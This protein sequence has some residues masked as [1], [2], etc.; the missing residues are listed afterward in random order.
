M[1]KRELKLNFKSFLIWTLILLGMFLAVF[2]VYPY[3]MTSENVDMLN[4][5]MK[6]FPPEVLKAF[7]MDISEIDTAFGWL[8]TEGFIFVLLISGIFS[9]ILGSNIVLKEESDKTIEYLHNL[10]I[11][12]TKIVT[13]KVLCALTYI[14]SMILVLGIFNYIGLSLSGDFNQ[15][16]YIL[17][18]ISP[19]FSALVTFSLCLFISTFTH[20]TK[21]TMG[22]SLGIVF[23]SYFLQILSELSDKVEFLKYISTFTL[24]DTRNIIS[25]NT[26]NPLCIIISILLTIFLI[27]LSIYK[28]NKKELV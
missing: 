25:N 22:I 16:Q 1:F 9:G 26:I 21:K 12:R 17:L 28:Y 18:S 13:N 27:I 10:P 4:E 20:K 11:T 14:I 2:L 15:K 7:N 6:V 3:I 24:A 23:A 8:K 5:M 19:L